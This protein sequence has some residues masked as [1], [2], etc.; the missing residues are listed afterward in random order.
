MAILEKKQKL[1][2]K[3]RFISPRYPYQRVILRPAFTTLVGME[4]QFHQGISVKFHRGLYETDDPEIVTLMRE[5][6]HF[7][8]NRG[9]FEDTNYETAAEI[10]ARLKAQKEAVKY[11]FYCKVCR[12]GF[13]TSKAMMAHMRS[14]SHKMA[15]KVE[16]TSVRVHKGAI[17]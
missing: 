13:D 6:F 10:S 4:K 8:T 2:K 9:W 5:A 17:S 1:P 15:E 11:N 3:V 7:N 12:K 16:E 14:N